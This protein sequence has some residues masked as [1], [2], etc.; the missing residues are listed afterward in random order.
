[1]P[2]NPVQIA[3]WLG[4]KDEPVRKSLEKAEPFTW[5][6]HLDKST[7]KSSRSPWYL[8]ALITEEYVH[9]Q[10]LL[11][12]TRTISEDSAVLQSES[13]STM[14]SR[15]PSFL[16]PS[17][18]GS[19]NVLGSSKLMTAGISFEPKATRTTSTDTASRKS[20]DSAFSSVAT[21]SSIFGT[22]PLSPVSSRLNDFVEKAVDRHETPD[23]TSFSDGSEVSDNDQPQL[24]ISVPDVLLQPPSSE[25]VAVRHL[26][27]LP[28]ALASSTGSLESTNPPPGPVSPENQS[29][30]SL[31]SSS[32][33]RRIRTSLHAS[34][35]GRRG[36]HRENSEESL[37]LEYEAKA[38]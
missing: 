30:S 27:P 28:L 35:P 34:R 2:L 33:H 16:S 38:A 26:A 11:D 3:R 20:A 7:S 22:V 10:S 24:L 12:R 18:L 17:R 4:T 21:G 14:N 8:S 23:D 15:S 32:N 25:D 1:V 5:L 36:R 13:H 6:K 19:A 9:A 31:K 29:L 37:R